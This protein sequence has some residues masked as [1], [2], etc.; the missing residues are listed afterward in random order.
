MKRIIISVE[1]GGFNVD[2]IQINEDGDYH[3]IRTLGW[4]KLEADAVE[5]ARR[6]A[7]EL[8]IPFEE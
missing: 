3:F 7:G 1:F 8:N 4:R 6:E 5:L 2:I